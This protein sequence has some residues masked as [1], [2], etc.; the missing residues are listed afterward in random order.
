MASTACD[1]I[2]IRLDIL[3]RDG[4]QIGEKPWSHL[5][6][7]P[8]LFTARCRNEGGVMD[9]PATERQAMIAAVAADANAVD[10]ELAHHQEMA[11]S[12][13]LL[14]ENKIPWVASMHHFSQM[15]TVESMRAARDAAHMLGATVFKLA[16]YLPT[17]EAIQE[18]EDFQH[19]PSEVAVASMGMG[20]FAATSRVRCALAGSVLNYGFIGQ[21]PTA[22]GQWPAEALRH[23]I[24]N[25]EI[26]AL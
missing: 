12:I 25:R 13:A 3:R 7:L 22:P 6:D 24:Q 15:P 21:A 9:L 11:A 19:E 18:L 14:S 8:L 5:H 16:T 4:W 1:W 10:I 17:A 26:P 20:P 23:A 2:E